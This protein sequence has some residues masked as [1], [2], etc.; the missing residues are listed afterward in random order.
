MSAYPQGKMLGELIL[1]QAWRNAWLENLDRLGID[2][3]VW[4]RNRRK[5]L[6]RHYWLQDAVL[7]QLSLCKSDEAR[8]LLCKW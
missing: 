5:H 3:T 6:K 1:Y 8:R 4:R 2:T 7:K